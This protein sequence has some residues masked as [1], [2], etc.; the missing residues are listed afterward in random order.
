MKM[1]FLSISD[2]FLFNDR[3]TYSNKLKDTF[4]NIGLFCKSS[5]YAIVKGASI[6]NDLYVNSSHNLGN[7][8]C[9][10]FIKDSYSLYNRYMDYDG[11][12]LWIDSN[13]SNIGLRPVIVFDKI[14]QFLLDRIIINDGYYSLYFG[15]YPRNVCPINRDIYLNILFN[16]G[17]LES[18]NDGYAFDINGNMDRKYK[19]NNEMFIKSKINLF[20]KNFIR[21]SNGLIYKNNSYVWIKV[22]PVEWIVDINNNMLIS[23]DVLLSGIKFDNRNKYNM[24]FENTKMYNFLNSYMINDMI[25]QSIDYKM[26]VKTK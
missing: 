16:R 1:S 24:S 10:Y 5:D 20:D 18:T 8:V 12:L 22:E 13:N 3:F 7:R 25:Y 21:L 17:N 2:M 26:R 19:Y 15:E 14:P 23:K 9:P 11:N 6:Y 4:K